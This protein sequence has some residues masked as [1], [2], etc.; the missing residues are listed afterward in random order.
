[1]GGKP[2]VQGEQLEAYLFCCSRYSSSRLRA[3]DSCLWNHLRNF[4]HRQRMCPFSLGSGN[5]ME[6][7]AGRL[8]GLGP[9]PDPAWT[10]PWGR[11]S[12]P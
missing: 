5:P 4:L 11:I 1:M 9:R 6:C 7:R 10:Q 12:S 2:G 3:H 8:G